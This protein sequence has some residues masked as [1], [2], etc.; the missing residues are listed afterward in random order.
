MLTHTRQTRAT[1]EGETKR[2]PNGLKTL[3]SNGKTTVRK[4][5]RPSPLP[6]GRPSSAGL[7]IQS[8]P[9]RLQPSSPERRSLGFKQRWKGSVGEHPA[10]PFHLPGQPRRPRRRFATP[11]PWREAPCYRRGRSGPGSSPW[12]R[13]WRSPSPTSLSRRKTHK[14]RQ[15][16]AAASANRR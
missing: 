7:R 13:P 9:E 1:G 12:P 3:G 4:A 14:P 8:T 5:R 11:P 10:R 6:R 2:G 15:A 16:L